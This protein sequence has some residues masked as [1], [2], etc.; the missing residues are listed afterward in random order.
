M[1]RL[2]NRGNELLSRTSA[3]FSEMIMPAGSHLDARALVLQ[4][5]RVVYTNY[6]F[7]S[8]FLEYRAD[9]I[10]LSFFAKLVR[11]YKLFLI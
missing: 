5:N 6:K 11:F 8:F 2:V 9:Y 10:L 3:R 1:W 7:K 4:S